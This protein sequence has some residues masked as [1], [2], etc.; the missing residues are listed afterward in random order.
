[1]AAPTASTLIIKQVDCGGS[2]LIEGLSEIFYQIVD[3]LGAYTE[4]YGRRIDLLL[5]LF[6]VGELR[7]GGRGRMDHEALHIGHI[8]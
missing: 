4:P 6:V 1:M 2:D 7:V 5:G 8:G 3:M